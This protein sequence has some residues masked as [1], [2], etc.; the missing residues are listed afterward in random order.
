[1]S[2]ECVTTS[3]TTTFAPPTTRKST[4][5]STTSTTEVIMTTENKGLILGNPLEEVKSEENALSVE[6]LIG[7]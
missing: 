6:L 7:K 2:P 1:M 4:T 3:T 5:T